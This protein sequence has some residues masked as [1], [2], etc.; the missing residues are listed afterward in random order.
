MIAV[1]KWKCLSDV[2]NVIDDGFIWKDSLCFNRCYI[3]HNIGTV[4]T[5]FMKKPYL[6]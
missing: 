4:N 3:A 1:L 5:G 2:L 6:L